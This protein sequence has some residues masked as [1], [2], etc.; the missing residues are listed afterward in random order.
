M[1]IIDIMLARAIT[2]QGQTDIYVNKANSAAAKAEKAKSDAEDAVA[3]VEAAAETIATTQENAD[4]LLASAQ[5]ALETAQAAQINTLDEED[6]DTEVNKMSFSIT[7]VSTS[8]NY[9]QKITATMP[10]GITT[11]DINDVAKLYKTTGSNEDG[12]MTQ[13]AIS[14]LLNTKANADTAATK[15]YVD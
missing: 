1:D 13:K 14:D 7:G 3:T 4:T 8:A 2:P 12:S 11:K 6:V 10:D 9:T 5:E 15:D